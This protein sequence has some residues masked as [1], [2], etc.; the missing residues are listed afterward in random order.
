MKASITYIKLNGPFKF[1][2]LSAKAFKIIKQLKTTNC[3]DFKKKG[4]WLEHYTMTLWEDESQMTE[5]VK[6]GAHLDAMKT[7]AEIAKEIR[8]TTI[9]AD[10]LPNWKE[11]K[12]LLED[13]KV[14]RF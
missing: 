8:T 2:I 3:K 9:D 11:A 7:S 14:L 1:F 6:S 12:S 5:F 13:A 4:I 10:K